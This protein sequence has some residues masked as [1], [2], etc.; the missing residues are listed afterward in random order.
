MAHFN[1]NHNANLYTALQSALGWNG[2]SLVNG[3]SAT[4][5]LVSILNVYKTWN[6]LSKRAFV[7]TCWIFHIALG[8]SQFIQKGSN[9]NPISYTPLVTLWYVSIGTILG[10]PDFCRL[11]YSVIFGPDPISLIG[12]LSLDGEI[13]IQSYVFIVVKPLERGTLYLCIVAQRKQREH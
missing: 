4:N 5:L 9:F 11:C 6:L 12:L 7:K 2:Y 3:H 1:W 8:Q 10:L 13:C